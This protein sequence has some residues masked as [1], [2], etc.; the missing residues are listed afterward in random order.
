MGGKAEIAASARRKFDLINGP[1][2]PGLRIP[3]DFRRGECVERI[4]KGS[5]RPIGLAGASPVP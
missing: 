1:L 5:P 2:L 3:T 4:V